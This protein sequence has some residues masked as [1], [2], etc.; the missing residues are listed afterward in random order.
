MLYKNTKAT[1]GSTDGDTDLFDIVTGVL[2][3]DTL[4]LYLFILCLDDILQTTI[5]IIK[6]NGFIIKKARSRRYSAETTTDIDYAENLALQT[7][8]PA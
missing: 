3:V 2:Q 6:G 7:N 5:D 1:V 4:V 8:T